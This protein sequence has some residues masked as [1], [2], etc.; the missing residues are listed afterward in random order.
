MCHCRRSLDVDVEVADR[1]VAMV[2]VVVV[3]DVVVVC[4]VAAFAGG[5]KKNARF[6]SIFLFF[7]DGAAVSADVLHLQRYRRG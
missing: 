5:P 6:F 7:L 4:G 3:D 1:D 2:E